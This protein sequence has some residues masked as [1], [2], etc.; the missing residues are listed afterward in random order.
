MPHCS[1]ILAKWLTKLY[2]VIRINYRF[3]SITNEKIR[4]QQLFVRIIAIV[5]KN[6][7]VA[8]ELRII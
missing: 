6:P 7:L 1:L 3:S 5:V 8:Y 4:S 2:I